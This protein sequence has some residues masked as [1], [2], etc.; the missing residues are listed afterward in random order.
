MYV[1]MYM[2]CMCIYIYDMICMICINIPL[3][4]PLMM[5]SILLVTFES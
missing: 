2:L 4:P 5:I 3:I 1:C